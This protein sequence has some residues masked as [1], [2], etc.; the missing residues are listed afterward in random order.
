MTAGIDPES[1]N[2]SLVNMPGGLQALAL[3]EF[4]QGPFDTRTEPAV[5]FADIKALLDQRG[6]QVPDL[7]LAEIDGARASR[8]GRPTRRAGRQHRDYP[9]VMIDDHMKSNYL[10]HTTHCDYGYFSIRARSVLYLCKA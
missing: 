1:L 8:L 3:L 5:N 9:A 2:R 6:L 10:C 4:H 7:L